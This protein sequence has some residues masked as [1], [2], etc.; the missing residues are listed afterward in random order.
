VRWADAVPDLLIGL[1]EGLEAGLVVSILLAALRKTTAAPPRT[2]QRQRVSA[3]PVWLGVLGAVMVS[4]SFT[5][6]FAFGPDALSSRAQE[7]VGGLFSVLAAGLVTGVIFWLRR[8]ARTLS[9][10]LGAEVTRGVAV[11]AGALTLTAFLAVGRE[12]LETTLVI[13]AAVKAPGSAIAPLIGAGLGLAAAVVLCWL[14]YRQAVRLDPGKFFNRG[15]VALIVIAAGVLAYGLGDLQEAGWLPGLHWIAF[16]LTAQADPGSWWMSII[17]GVTELTPKLTVLQLYAW[18]GYLVVVMPAFALAR[19]TAGAPAGAVRSRGLA[20]RWET[21]WERIAARNA[22]RVAGGLVAAPALVAALVI[23]ALPASADPA[24]ATSVT[25]TSR[26]CAPQWSSGHTGP[27]TFYVDNQSGMAGG[28]S[29]DN[30]A[31]AVVAEIETIGPATTVSMPATLGAGSY[32]FVC[33]M[34]GGTTRS[35]PVQVT[36]SQ[37]TTTFAVKPVTA[38]ELEVPNLQYQAYAA[39]DLVTLQ[40]DVSRIRA[41]LAAGDLA[42][43]RQDWLTAQMDWERVGASYDSFGAAGLAVDGLPGGLPLGVNDP[44]FTGLHRL[45]YGLYHGQSAAELLPVVAKLSTDITTVRQQLAVSPNLAG[46]PTNLPVRAHEILEDALRDHLSGIDNEGAGAAYPETYADTQVT[47]TILGELQP[48]I[49][50]REPKLMRVLRTQLAALQ[51]AL[52]ATRSGGQW[53]PAGQV[54]LAAG[55][56]VDSAIGALLQNLATVPDLLQVPLSPRDSS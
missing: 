1:R 48:L 21:R 32:T 3:A 45:E 31:G 43:A 50:S 42:A 29:L 16:D 20:A 35:A 17:T 47:A 36:G 49:T 12:G 4:G 27:Q 14:L 5:A 40:G 9:A 37:Q 2:A 15:A 44:G 51:A 53:V 30:A 56:Q 34:S 38:S 23:V 26:E 33:V 6:V 55:E 41:D 22:W 52:L 28:V 24:S 18:A 7:T 54:P 46:D 11:G 39:A 10:R 13:W 25:V 19:G 8:T